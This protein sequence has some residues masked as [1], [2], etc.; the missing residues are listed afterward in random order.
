VEGRKEAKREANFAFIILLNPNVPVVGLCRRP[1]NTYFSGRRHE[2][3]MIFD[4]FR[5]GPTCRRP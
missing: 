1:A 2:P 3:T 5:T 4:G